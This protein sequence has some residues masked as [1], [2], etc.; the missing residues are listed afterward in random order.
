MEPQVKYFSNVNHRAYGYNDSE[1]SVVLEH[2]LSLIYTVIIFYPLD[3][4]RD[5]KI[6]SYTKLITPAK[7]F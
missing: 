2:D 3:E 7:D 6:N 5:R 1:R 4:D